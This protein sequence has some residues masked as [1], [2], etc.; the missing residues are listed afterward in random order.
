MTMTKTNI[1]I[2]KL[3]ESAV[4]PEYATKGAAGF[5]FR[6]IE[7][8][9]L[10]PYS[11]RKV[12]TGLAIQLPNGYELQIRPRSG[13]AFK[14]GITIL[15]SPGTI[16]SDY[17]GEIGVLLYNTTAK[18]VFI[19]KGDRIAQGIISKHETASFTLVEELETTERG[20]GGF[21]ST[22]KK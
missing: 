10:A 22:G 4:I 11:F 20:E 6:S 19:E 7:D 8:T 1:K 15:N 3:T 14:N 9:S 16:D 18:K 5:D 12:S 2:K 13:L 21:G 17:T